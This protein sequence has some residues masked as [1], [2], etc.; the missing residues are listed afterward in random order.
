M[1]KQKSKFQNPNI[2]IKGLIKGDVVFVIS[3]KDKGKS[4]KILKVFPKKEKIIVEGVNILKKH[5]RPRRQGEKGEIIQMSVPIHISN[6]MLKCPQC[7]L[8]TKRAFK[9]LEGDKKTR[10]CKKCKVEI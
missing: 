5:I 2:K 9:I 3:G 8:A 7:G 1:I 4:G 10:I 6:V